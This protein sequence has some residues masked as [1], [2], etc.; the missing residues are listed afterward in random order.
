MHI[1]WFNLHIIPT[2]F[3][4]VHMNQQFFHSPFF[5]N[6]LEV[7]IYKCF[8]FCFVFTYIIESISDAISSSPVIRVNLCFDRRLY[9]YRKILLYIRYPLARIVD[10]TVKTSVIIF[11]TVLVVQVSEKHWFKQCQCNVTIPCNYKRTRYFWVT[12]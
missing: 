9:K 2:I 5:Y 6:S 7:V 11:F 3:D 4:Q 12:Y 8:L 10:W 1:A